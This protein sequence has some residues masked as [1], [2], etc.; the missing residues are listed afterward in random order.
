MKDDSLPLDSL[1]AAISR[2]SLQT[3]ARN[4]FFGTIIERDNLQVQQH[5]NVQLSDKKTIIHAAL[6]E[7]SADRL[8]LKKR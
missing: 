6:T 3:S 7:K 1:L 8:G 5:V 2:F 4:Q